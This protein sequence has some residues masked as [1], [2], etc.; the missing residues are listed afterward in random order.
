VY[1]VKDVLKGD[2][3]TVIKVE[4]VREIIKDDD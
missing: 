1:F 2:D 3:K 4:M